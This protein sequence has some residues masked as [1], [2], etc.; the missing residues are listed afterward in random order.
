M[1]ICWQQ[2]QKQFENNVLMLDQISELRW[3][4][5]LLGRKDSVT[6]YMFVQWEKDWLQTEPIQIVRFFFDGLI[7]SN[8]IDSWRCSVYRFLMFFAFKLSLACEG[9]VNFCYQQPPA[10][11][12]CFKKRIFLTPPVSHWRYALDVAYRK[13]RM[14]LP[15]IVWCIA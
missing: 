13:V 7:P 10:T 9:R 12:R 5:N 1:H 15:D 6:W 2:D 11:A 14:Y 4:W 3:G 8:T